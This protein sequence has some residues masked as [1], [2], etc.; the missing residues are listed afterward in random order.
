MYSTVDWDLKSLDGYVLEMKGEVRDC[1][2]K[3]VAWIVSV[4]QKIAPYNT[5]RTSL[6]NSEMLF[7]SNLVWEVM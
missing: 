3:V 2:K 4:I 5:D 6:R 7:W 1:N